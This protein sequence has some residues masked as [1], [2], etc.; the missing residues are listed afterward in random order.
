MIRA[1]FFVRAGA[2][3]GF[4]LT[5]HADRAPSG[6]DIVCAA[7]SSAA[8]MTVNT[9]TEVCRCPAD[10]RQ[11]EQA[12]QMTVRIAPDKAASCRDVLQGF[13]LHMQGLAQQY[14]RHIQTEYTEV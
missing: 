3:C 11:D 4:S 8:Y 1:V 9:I 7:V 2:V 5:G 10:I 6:K 13:Y 12:G 14:P